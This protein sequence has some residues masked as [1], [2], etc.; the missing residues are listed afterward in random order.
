MNNSFHYNDVYPDKKLELIIN[1]DYK[2]LKDRRDVGRYQP[3]YLYYT[4]S[5]SDSDNDNDIKNEKVTIIIPLP[6]ELNK[7]VED[8]K[9]DIELD[10]EE[11]WTYWFHNFFTIYKT[12]IASFLTPLLNKLDNSDLISAKIIV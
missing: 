2:K 10:D 7:Y 3:C 1:I 9:N 4:D 8:C 11:F 6:K 12:N 5:D